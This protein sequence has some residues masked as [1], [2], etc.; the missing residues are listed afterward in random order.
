MSDRPHGQDWW[1]ASDGKW[2]P[3]E[4]HAN[5]PQSS[6]SA[7][8]SLTALPPALS[9]GLV[10]ATQAILLSAAALSA[11][12]AIGLAAESSSFQADEVR[13]AIDIAEAM[14]PSGT[15]LSLAMMA[16]LA[17]TVLLIVWGYQAYRAAA[18][19]GATGTTW[20]P[21]WAIGGWFIPVA[22]LVI[23]KLVVGEIDRMS[24]PDAGL[25][26]IE[27]RWKESPSL[28]LGHWWWAL[29]VV[30][31]IVLTF[32]FTVVAEQLDSFSLVE[33]TYRAGLQ[34]TAAGLAL[35]AGGAV[36]GAVIVGRIGSRLSRPPVNGADGTTH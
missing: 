19:R 2:Y 30:S 13:A 11:L 1:L 32:G 33:Q 35:W 5:Q 21:G 16:L 20:A 23:P 3:P 25:A 18:G 7:P 24:H 10:V 26:P 28:M 17:A 27:D 6:A 34:A 22:N 29:T 12:A 9:P 31:G 15:M 14:G 4:A 36:T 8:G